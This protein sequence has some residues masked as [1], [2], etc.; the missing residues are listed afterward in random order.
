[1]PNSEQ[2][3]RDARL[4]EAKYALGVYYDQWAARGAKLE[5][6][7]MEFNNEAKQWGL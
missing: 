5:E 7:G 3:E 2:F 4:R 1:M 6:W